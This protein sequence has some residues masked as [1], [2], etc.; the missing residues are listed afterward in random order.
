VTSLGSARQL[1]WVC[2]LSVVLAIVGVLGTWRSVGPVSLDGLEGP[3]DGWL[4]VIFALVG[5]VGV[6]S[7]SRGGWLGIVAVAG[8]ASAVLYLAL[9]DLVDDASGLGGTS[10]WGIWLTIAGSAMLACCAVAAALG[11]L[12]R[13]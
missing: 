6:R 3:H 12:R 4:V 13:V 11:R 7:L 2:G 10:G 9:S 8:S 5:L 1:A